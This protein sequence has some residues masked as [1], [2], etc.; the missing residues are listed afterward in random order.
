MK[1]SINDFLSANPNCTNLAAKTEAVLVFEH[2]SKDASIIKMID[3]CDAGKPALTPV[4]KEIEDLISNLSNPG[5]SFD[6]TFTK[7]AVGLMVKAILEP[8]G[9]IV[10]SQK[11][12]PKSAQAK[13]FVSASCY[14]FNPDANPTMRIVKKV[15]SI[16]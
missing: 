13:K 7:Q 15:E 6:D 14:K 10:C 9:Y 4:A 8:F 5:I 16:E 3:A 1:S 12:L 11:S 2:L